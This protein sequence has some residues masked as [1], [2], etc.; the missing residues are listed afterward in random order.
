MI[1]T[2][3]KTGKMVAE[4]TF[5]DT[6]EMELNLDY[7]TLEF[8]VEHPAYFLVFNAPI[9]E[10]DVDMSFMDDLLTKLWGMSPELNEEEKKRLNEYLGKYR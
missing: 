2:D 4:M 5:Y 6:T 3:S 7:V 10:I 9:S 8:L 1:F